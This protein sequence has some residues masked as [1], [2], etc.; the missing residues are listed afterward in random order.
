MV[1]RRRLIAFAAAILILV[2]LAAP[3]GASAEPTAS[4]GAEMEQFVD[5]LS[6]GLGPFAPVLADAF[7]AAVGDGEVWAA[8]VHPEQSKPYAN[9]LLQWFEGQLPTLKVLVN[10]INRDLDPVRDELNAALAPN[11]DWLQGELTTIL[12]ILFNIV[13][14]VGDDVLSPFICDTLINVLPGLAATFWPVV[15]AF[16]PFILGLGGDFLPVILDFLGGMLSSASGA[17]AVS[18][19]GRA[20][21][22]V[23]AAHLHSEILTP[24]VGEL[25][26]WLGEALADPALSL[27]PILE[28]IAPVLGDVIVDGGALLA[29]A[30]SQVNTIMDP[31]IELVCIVADDIG[32][33]NLGCMLSGLISGMAGNVIGGVLDT[34]GDWLNNLPSY[35][36]PDPSATTTTTS[37]CWFFCSGSASAASVDLA[38]AS[39]SGSG[40]S[41]SAGG[42]LPLTGTSVPLGIL[43]L[44]I[45]AMAGALWVFRRRVA[46]A[47]A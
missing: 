46:D 38:S 34:I 47:G 1:V 43:G 11:A 20:S 41:A 21:T 7:S 32:I 14:T 22:D 12:P 45:S 36:P 19:I 8:H 10:N 26:A 37:T 2:R 29:W 13:C 39:G 27:I 33:V 28:A 9:E 15:M 30:G 6:S 42:E 17:E 25:L 23:E 3:A 5:E 44:A 16:L 40:P 31:L 24:Y 18:N 35:L 4:T